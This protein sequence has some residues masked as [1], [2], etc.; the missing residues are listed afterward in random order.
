MDHQELQFQLQFDTRP[1]IVT[2]IDRVATLA[3]PR[4]VLRGRCSCGV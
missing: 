4:A 3:R 1:R 2:T